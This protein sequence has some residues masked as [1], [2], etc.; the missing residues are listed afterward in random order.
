VSFHDAILQCGQ[1]RKHFTE[2]I[3]APLSIGGNVIA[4]RTVHK[5]SYATKTPIFY[6]K[7]AAPSAERE[8]KV[9]MTPSH[10]RGS[11]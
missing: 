3:T 8:T 4:R 5:G 10:R 1:L 2:V 11:V 7:R 6:V 9:F